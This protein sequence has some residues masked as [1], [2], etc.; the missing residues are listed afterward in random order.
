L[1]FKNKI[2]DDAG[3]DGGYGERIPLG[4]FSP[5][6]LRGPDGISGHYTLVAP[7]YRW[8]N[9]TLIYAYD[10]VLSNHSKSKTKFPLF[11]FSLLKMLVTF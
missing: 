7:K 10:P 11:D 6:D 1:C 4:S 9:K 8:P 2:L 3:R 5:D